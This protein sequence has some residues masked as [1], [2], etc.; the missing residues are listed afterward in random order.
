[1]EAILGSGGIDGV[2]GDGLVDGGMS[3]LVMG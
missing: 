3:L 1:M 2:R